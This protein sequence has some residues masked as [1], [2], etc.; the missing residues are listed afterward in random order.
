MNRLQWIQ[1]W[2]LIGF[3]IAGLGGC[4]SAS[5]SDSMTSVRLAFQV[6]EAGEGGLQPLQ[7]VPIGVASIRIMVT[8]EGMDDLTDTFN[9]TPG[10]MVTRTFPVPSGSERV[11]TVTAYNS[12]G[13]ALYQ[14]QSNPMDL[15]PGVPKDVSI[16]MQILL[17]SIEVIPVDLTISLGLQQQLTAMGTYGDGTTQDLT[18]SVAWSSSNTLVATISGTG[19]V[20]AL[21][22]GTATITATDP[23]TGLSGTTPLTVIAAVLQSISVTP[24]NPSLAVGLTQPFTAIGTYTDSSTQNLT[25][26]VAWS[27]SATGVATISGT[28]IATGLTGGT[29]TITATLG[30]IS[31]STTLAVTPVLNRLSLVDG[32]IGNTL[33]MTGNGFGSTQGASTVSIGGVNA[34]T[35]LRWTSTEIAAIIPSGVTVSSTG[36]SN[37]V[38][39]TVGGQ[40]SNL[41]SVTLF[42]H[43]H[44]IG[45]EPASVGELDRFILDDPPATTVTVNDLTRLFNG[46]SSSVVLSGDG[47]TA[48]AADSVAYTERVRGFDNGSHI[49]GSPTLDEPDFFGALDAA[50]SRNGSVVLLADETDTLILYPDF[51]AAT[52]TQTTFTGPA[53]VSFYEVA[54]T[55][56]GNT[57]A[58]IGQ[59]SS[60]GVWN[61]YRINNVLGS[62]AFTFIAAA[63]SDFNS[64]YTD[65][66]ISEDGKTV[67]AGRV[68]T[69]LSP[70]AGVHR[71]RNFTT[72]PVP[73]TTSLASIA[74]EIASC[75]FSTVDVDLSA[76]GM[77]A[78]VGLVNA[79]GHEVW[80]IRNADLAA[81]SSA[82]VDTPPNL[83][84]VALNSGGSIALVRVNDSIGLVKVTRIDGFN[85]SGPTATD[86]TSLTNFN[87]ASPFRN[88]DQIDLQ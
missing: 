63:G 1:G 2:M 60:S 59:D 23:E 30:G 25:G 5:F 49:A 33:K 37:S 32:I 72:S 3:L 45:G 29:T 57:A 74:T 83:E 35:I 87:T 16:S 17:L 78:I 85:L 26:S 51:T 6:P 71:I 21:A 80:Q 52:P 39:A 9:V 31:G 15:E 18:G 8:G 82:Q 48:A 75:P 53:G 55:S 50:I 84:G 64:V 62:P 43:T 88:Q 61:V 22:V 38:L 19:L 20:T 27:S 56:D 41:M 10:D 67:I 54:L 73:D 14:G 40:P 69:G 28:G 46:E 76:D 24:V 34:A 65:V 13:I 42:D 86:I 68:V 12:L 70:V 47:N 66:A 77:T 79:C 4:E 11:F 58:V 81:A 44:G 7:A 36:T